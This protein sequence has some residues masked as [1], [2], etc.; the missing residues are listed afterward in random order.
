M[1]AKTNEEFDVLMQQVM[2]GSETAAQQLF[3]DYEFTLLNAIRRR[4]SRRIR[5]KFDSMDF[6]QD[7][8]ASFFAER[9]DKRVFRSADDLVGFLTRVAEN[10][11]V[12]ALRQHEQTLKHG[13]EPEESLDD[14]TRFDKGTL[15]GEQPTPSQVMMTHEEW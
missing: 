14:S 8:W 2:N 9:A 6:V 1:M 15:V 3:N 13:V 4:L 7:V 12:D 11:V 10:K 5:L